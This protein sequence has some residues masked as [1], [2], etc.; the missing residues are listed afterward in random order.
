MPLRERV[1]WRLL[2]DFAARAEEA[3]GL[4]IGD[5]DL[6]SRQTRARIKGG[7]VRPPPT[8]TRQRPG[9]AVL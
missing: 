4:D 5:L 2:Y 7:H 9:P 3:L 8:W 1:L 6:A